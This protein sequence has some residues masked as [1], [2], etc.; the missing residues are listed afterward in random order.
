VAPEDAGAAGGVTNVAHQIGGSLGLG[1]LVAVSRRRT[2][3]RCTGRL[4]HR[5]AASLTVGAGMLALAFVIALVVRRRGPT[6]I[7]DNV[8]AGTPARRRTSPE[9]RPASRAVCTPRAAC[10]P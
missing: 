8:R 3:R 1:I 6:D 5:I 10:W 9:P 2:P 4:A 7:A